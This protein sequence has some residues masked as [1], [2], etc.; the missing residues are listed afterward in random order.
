MKGNKEKRD[1][2]GKKKKKRIGRDGKKLSLYSSE[3]FQ[4]EEKNI[5][6]KKK[7]NILKL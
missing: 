7:I 5:Y 6:K 1:V 3:Y 4:K 2:G